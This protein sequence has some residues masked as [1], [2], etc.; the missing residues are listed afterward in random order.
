MILR[1]LIATFLCLTPALAI[2][3]DCPG[4]A[5]GAAAKSWYIDAQPLTL[6]GAR[7]EKY[8]LP[9]VLGAGDVKR[10][11]VTDGIAVFVVPGTPSPPDVVYVP[12]HAGCEFQPYQLA[13]YPAVL[14]KKQHFKLGQTVVYTGHA[15][16]QVR[17][18]VRAKYATLVKYTPPLDDEAPP[19]VDGKAGKDVLIPVTFT[20]NG[21]L[22][23]EVA[24]VK[25]APKNAMFDVTIE[26]VKPAK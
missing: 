23:I 17:L 12:V 1:G 14:G 26:A 5:D 24:S 6:Y 3:D 2:A 4:D 7:Y 19:V 11:A 20:D 8:G 13:G 10:G 18:R 16:D 22:R 21:E 25:P 15:G 9:R